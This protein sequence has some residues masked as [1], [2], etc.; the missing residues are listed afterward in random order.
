MRSARIFGDIA[1]NSRGALAGRV[2]RKIQV[3]FSHLLIQAQV[4]QSRFDQRAASIYIELKHTVHA[5]K[6]NNQSA[7]LCNRPS[8]KSRTCSAPDQRN[9]MFSRPARNQRQVLRRLGQYHAI[10]QPMI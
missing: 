4:N 9:T 10:W 6:F 5:R 7:L 2:R 3:M 8:R 1:A